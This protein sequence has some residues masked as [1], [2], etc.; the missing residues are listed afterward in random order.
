MKKNKNSKQKKVLDIE[1]QLVEMLETLEE[2]YLRNLLFF[3]ENYPKVYKKLEKLHIAVESGSINEEYKIEFNNAIKSLDIFD[4]SNDKFIYQ[5]DMYEYAQEKLIELDFKKAKQIVFVGS[6]LC[7]HISLIAK[8]K[9]AK[10]I[11]IFEENYQ[12]FRLSLFITD[13]ESLAKKTKISFC[14]GNTLDDKK[15]QKRFKKFKE[16]FKNSDDVKIVIATSLED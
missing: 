12:I 3:R 10:N 16:N 2:L 6:L 4:M 14:L 11:M 7:T 1:P 9:K 8:E 5:K 13:F 15:T